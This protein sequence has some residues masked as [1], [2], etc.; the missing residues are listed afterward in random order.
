MGKYRIFVPSYNFGEHSMKIRGPT[1]LQRNH[2]IMLTFLDL[3][4]GG[5][6]LDFP[7]F[8]ES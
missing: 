3:E 2:F 1:D 4:E 6:I 7:Q 8:R 5:G